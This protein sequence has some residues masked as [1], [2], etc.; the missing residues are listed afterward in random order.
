M[1]GGV[2]IQAAGEVFPYRDSVVIPL[3]LLDML[4][5]PIEAL[6]AGYRAFHRSWP[7]LVIW[8]GAVTVRPVL[9]ACQTGRFGPISRAFGS[10]DGSNSV[11]SALRASPVL[12]ESYGPLGGV[13]TKK[14]R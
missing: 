12:G 8:P 9:W 1:V 13:K 7:S 3:T 2:G 5:F 14:R 10:S 4:Q 6:R 11:E